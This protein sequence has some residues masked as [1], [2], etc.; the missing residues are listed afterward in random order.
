M[1]RGSIHC[2]MQVGTFSASS[3]RRR[4][5]R[6]DTSSMRAKL[7]RTVGNRSSPSAVSVSPLGVRLNSAN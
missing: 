4:D 1:M 3:V 2:I 6:I 5:R 7:S